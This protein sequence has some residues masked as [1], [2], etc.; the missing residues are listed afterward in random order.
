MID[1]LSI[2]EWETRMWHACDTRPNTCL[3]D[4]VWIC[5]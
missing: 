5:I 3:A 2:K 4:V 1:V